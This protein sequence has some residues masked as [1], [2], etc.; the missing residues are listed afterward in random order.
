MGRRQQVA[1][2]GEAIGRW[3]GRCD[4]FGRDPELGEVAA[5]Q[6]LLDRNRP[7]RGAAKTLQCGGIGGLG[8]GERQNPGIFAEIDR[9]LKDVETEALR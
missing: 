4:R 5:V 6:C 1:R 3:L 8:R 9:V 2:I 7:D